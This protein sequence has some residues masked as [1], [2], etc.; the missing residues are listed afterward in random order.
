MTKLGMKNEGAADRVVRV[1][2]GA[3]LIGGAAMGPLAPWGWIGVVPLAT[4]I[5]GS[6]PLYSLL[7]VSTCPLRESTATK[8]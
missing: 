3:A 1:L 8:S 4:G 5:L 6:C 2:A 7:G